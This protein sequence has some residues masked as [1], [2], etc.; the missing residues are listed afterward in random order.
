VD[1]ASARAH[2]DEPANRLRG[3]PAGREA[4]RCSRKAAPSCATDR[5][6]AEGLSRFYQAIGGLRGH[7]VLPPDAAARAASLEAIRFSAAGRR[8]RRADHAAHNETAERDITDLSWPRGV[9]VDYI[10]T[11]FAVTGVRASPFVSKLA[12]RLAREKIDHVL[13]PDASLLNYAPLNDLYFVAADAAHVNGATI[14]QA[15]L[16]KA[17]TRVLQGGHDLFWASIY[18][19][20][21]QQ[22]MTHMVSTIARVAGVDPEAALAPIADLLVPR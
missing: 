2:P 20:E 15:Q 22:R 3:R 14:D 16:A 4:S 7:A 5:P 1:R 19:R 10:V 11:A 8:P 9:A 13:G 17:L 6:T 12:T 21:D 18:N